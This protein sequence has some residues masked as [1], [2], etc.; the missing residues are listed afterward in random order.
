MA[1][2]KPTEG[3]SRRT[4]LAQVKHAWSV[5]ILSMH[6]ALHLPCSAN[7]AHL[8]A[9]SGSV[10]EESCIRILWTDRKVSVRVRQL[11]RWCGEHGAFFD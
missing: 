10:Y 7:C 9:K 3:G 11:C 2:K 5:T 6:L 1:F 8:T 4:S